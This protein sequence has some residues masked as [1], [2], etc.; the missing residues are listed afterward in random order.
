M[1]PRR[2]A[3]AA[4]LLLL[5]AGLVRAAS[6]E[7]VGVLG[8]SGRAGAGL[9]RVSIPDP[10][11][12][13]TGVAAD[14]E[15]TIWVGGGDRINRL[16]ID[17]HRI[18]SH[19]LRPAG[20][21]VDSRTFAVLDGSL[22][23]L[24]RTPDGKESLFRLPMA[25]GAEARPVR[26]ALPAR[27]NRTAAY[28]LSPQPLDGALA[29]AA[30]PAG[31]GADRIGVYRIDPAGATVRQ[32]FAVAGSHPMGLAVDAIR[33]WV[34]LGGRFG[35]FVG[36]T[37]HGERFSI[38]A[39]TADGKLASKAF[40]AVC[41]KTPAIPSQF[42]GVLSLAAGAVW[43]SAWYGFLARLDAQAAAD[44]GRIVEW[45]HELDYA[46]Q[47]LGIGETLGGGRPRSDAVLIATPL[48]DALYYAAWRRD[49]RRL[50]L[51]RRIGCLPVISSLG[52]SEAG[53]VTVA[54]GRAHLWW[55]WEDPADAPPRK[56]ELHVPVT[57]PVF[58]RG[59][60][61]A[62][63]A[64]YRLHSTR[65]D[66]LR[67]MIFRRKPGARNEARRVGEALPFR[68]PVGLAARPVPAGGRT[69]LF[70]TDAAGKRIWRTGFHAQSL[71]PGGSTWKPIVLEGDGLRE[72]T[73]LAALT[74]GRLLVADAGGIEMLEPQGPAYRRAWRFDRWGDG[75]GER[76]G[77]RVRFAL[78]GA[79]LLVADCDRH[80]LVWL[81]WTRRKVLARFG[82]TDAAGPGP[83]ELN[84]PE[85]VALRGTRAVV[86][87]AGNQ[88]VVQLLLH[89]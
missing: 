42:R 75:P 1:I 73:D 36:G 58:G 55:R 65:R 13:A 38:A 41:T 47:V 77:R 78:D 35:A 28:C 85:Q 81:D 14:A 80:R 66:S 51:L 3:A 16:G 11:R 7:A 52:L 24:G 56:A 19:P 4:L 12:C 72:P 74:D 83:A 89:P 61:F 29:L 2:G 8:N 39:F 54:T 21:A 43:E 84:A 67:A 33:G 82:R 23:F 57:P 6:I 17:G 30:Q 68:R 88:R 79:S 87:D 32:A 40:P 26:V 22:Y 25:P 27:A 48:P 9:V 34:Y 37:T 46:T 64:P 63:G 50:D 45:H 18:E 49:R 62:L 10:R 44:P 53:D 20:S 76:F 31:D 71:Q 69:E 59:E 60:C 5:S 70:A 15:G 86:A